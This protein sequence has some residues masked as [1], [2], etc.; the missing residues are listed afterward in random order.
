MAPWAQA[1]ADKLD[2]LSSI[3]GAYVV[4]KES[5]ISK[6]SSDHTACTH[7]CGCTTHIK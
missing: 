1:P 3:P 2:N 5:Q 6:L 7:L 4:E